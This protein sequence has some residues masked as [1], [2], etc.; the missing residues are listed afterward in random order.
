MPFILGAQDLLNERTEGT[1]FR[2]ND[3]KNLPTYKSFCQKIPEIQIIRLPKES[4]EWLYPLVY[5]SHKPPT[6]HKM[7]QGRTGNWGGEVWGEERVKP[8]CSPVVK[9]INNNK[10]DQQQQKAKQKTGTVQVSRLRYEPSQNSAS[11]TGC[12]SGST[13]PSKDLI[14]PHVTLP[15]SHLIYSLTLR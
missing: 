2:W 10:N 3:L 9:G 7:N 14:L 1:K 11:R 6:S 5:S 4:Y 8:A 13:T 15:L 12:S